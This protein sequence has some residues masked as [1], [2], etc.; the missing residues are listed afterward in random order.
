MAEPTWRARWL[1]KTVKEL[2]DESGLSVQE[3]GE[4]LRRVKSVVS[5]FES[6]QNPIPG[7]DLL[8]LLDLYGVSDM[9]QRADMLRL[10]K[11]VTQRG[12]WDNYEP[13][14]NRNFTDYLWLEDNAHTVNVLALTALPGLT[15]TREYM[16]A[17]I[18]H[19]PE[20]GDDLQV[21]RTVEARLMRHQVFTGKEPKTLR[22]L[23]HEPVLFQ[24]FEE[25]QLMRDQFSHLLDMI[26]WPHVELRIL[27][28]ECWKHI[29]A[30]ITVEF[31]HFQ[32]P[33]PLPEVVCIDSSAVTKFLEAPDVDSFTATFDALWNEEALDKARTVE[34]IR[35]ILKDV[36]K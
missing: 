10:A 22:F 23:V 32:L 15:Q 5:K 1:G 6:G 29:A 3:V 36:K 7:D 4:Y 26:E 17:L 20:S 19:G 2:R 30:G 35:E 16:T 14:I 12:W 28:K 18:S 27:P 21:Q 33:E 8:K 9:T 25:D 11:D 24:R 34:C 13:Y 31:T